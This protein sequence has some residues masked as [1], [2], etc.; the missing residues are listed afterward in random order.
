MN[1][2]VVESP[3]KAKTIN[4]YLGSGY[5]VLASFGHVRDLPAKDG[6]V[7]PD[8]DFAMSWEV[9]AA[10][11]KR[12]KDITDALKGA[13]SLILATDPDREGEAIS[14]HV[15]EVLTKKKALKDKKVSRVVFNAITKK[16]VLD[17]MDNPR[18]ID[19]PLVDAY[20]A[21]RALDYL[22]GFN[23]SPVLWRKLP[24]ARSAG[25]VQSV[26]LRLVCDRES[27]IER[28]NSEEYWQISADL[29]TPRGDGFTARLTSHD[30]EKMTKMSVTGAD[31]AG[32]IKE[33][34]E[35]ASFVADSVEAKPTRRNPSAPFTTSTLQ[36]AASSKL[37][38]NA[39][40]TM[41]VAQR[42]YEGIDI[43]GE[44]V[45]LITYMR[46]DGVQM[47]PEAIDE[48][49]AAIAERFGARYCPEKPRLYS[50]KAK[51]AQEAH[52]AIRPTG[53]E[54]APDDLK[55]YLDADQ[56]KLYDL[57]WKRAIAS[58]MASAEIE[59][60]TVDITATKDG[61]TAGLRATGSVVRFD[62]FIA[63]YTDA[64]EDGE[65]S[66]G[67]DDD[68]ARLPEIN[69][70]E[71]LAKN[72]INATQHF[73]E[74]PP[75]Y[76][77]ASLIKKM[78]ELGIGRPS[79][80]ASTLATLR[81]RDYVV[82]DKR[83]LIPEA[84]GR[85]VIAFLE[86]FFERYVE[87]GFTADLEEKLDRISAGELAWKDVLREFWIEFHAHID[88]TKDLRV[89]QVLDALNEAL[90]PLV[91]PV[92]EDGSNPRIC[93]TCGTG[94]LSLK[95]G[96][97][98]A[99]V[100][101]SNYPDCNFTRQLSND[102]NT[103]ADAALSNEPKDLGK[104]P[105]TEEPITL[106]TGR[107]GPYVQRGDGKEAKR[108]SLPKG[109]AVDTI[110]H[111]KA[112]AL[113][114]LPRDI[115]QHPESGKLISAGLGRYGPFLLHDGG[116]A[117]LESVEDV[118]SI[119]LNRAVTVIAEKAAKGPGRGRGTPAALK[120]LGD[121]PDGGPVTVRDGKYGP[122]VNWG[123]VNATLPKDKAPTEVTLEQALEMIT[124]KAGA[125]GKKAPAKK[126][127]PKKAAAKKATPAKTA[128][129]PKAKAKKPAAAK[130]KKD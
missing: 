94:N 96:K 4:K 68:D 90:A 60:T 78:E 44:T 82:I 83:R 18:Q 7:L 69:A 101:C 122:Y 65:Q 58:Q 48:A 125:S 103:E 64:K 117:N 72:K 92:R 23:L 128:A 61:K 95:L 22:V 89:T 29:K 2:V 15:L 17:A 67:D 85:L 16:S 121:H 55:R 99:F 19:T 74:P 57:I 84:K 52:E 20:L 63:A 40:R 98:G 108:S 71:A 93:P 124:A 86:N 27:E 112:V 105:H 102:P 79:T 32:R 104:D 75:R 73:T 126:A 115:G 77:E 30:G 49:R 109:W 26:A 51:N 38:F 80:Y 97:Y 3:A 76:S 53:F 129:K 118:F 10:S 106:R 59:R 70:Q 130:A 28:F 91:F 88:E 5:K 127:A 9:D 39:S 54:R 1:V 100:G 37:G 14:W 42:L 113:L 110:D 12:L 81:D 33:M 123:K 43:G 6:S 120:T 45:G 34:L 87:F 114:S 107:F 35:G 50:T 13:D 46:T 36:Q 56:L 41:Q 66:D 25:R 111:E 62:G 11:N 47:A 21:R 24:G 8:E 116:Y 119:G 31:L